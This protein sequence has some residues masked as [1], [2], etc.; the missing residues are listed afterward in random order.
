MIEK[1]VEHLTPQAKDKG[2]KVIFQKPK[3]PLTNILVDSQMFE[4][5]ITRL[6][7]NAILYTEKGQVIVSTDKIRQDSKEFLQVSVKDT[8]LGLTEEN[9][10]HL[11]E[12]F[13]RGQKATLAH[14]NG[15]GLALF[16]VKELVKAHQGKIWA[17]SAGEGKGAT[18]TFVLPIVQEV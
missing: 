18:F 13:Y 12:L 17:E 7:D 1:Q 8:G 10:Q 9:K 6:I 15:S 2:N 16:I 5:I 11:F 4:R 14:A 3:E